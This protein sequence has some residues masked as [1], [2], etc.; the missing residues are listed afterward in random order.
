M[1]QEFVTDVHIG[2]VRLLGG[3]EGGPF[4]IPVVDNASAEAL[5]KVHRHLPTQGEV[6]QESGKGQ[7]HEWTDTG[8]QPVATRRLLW[9]HAPPF[10]RRNNA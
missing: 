10:P 6:D 1:R 7:R 4:S 2:L 5:Y 9:F 8:G 3:G